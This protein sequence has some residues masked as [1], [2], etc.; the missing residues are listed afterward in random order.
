M[1]IKD[2]GSI[3]VSLYGEL[4]GRAGAAREFLQIGLRSQSPAFCFLTPVRQTI[5][6]SMVKGLDAVDR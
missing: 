4:T 3:Q 2:T 1:I 5:R 6:G